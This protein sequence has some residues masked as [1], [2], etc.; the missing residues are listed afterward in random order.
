MQSIP[1]SPKISVIVPIY[2]VERY[3]RLCLDSI[4]T[5]TFTDFELLLINDGS[6]DGCPVICNEYAEK[7][8]RIRVFHKSNGGVASARNEGL[9]YAK[10]DW[11]MYIDGDDWI[12][13]TYIEDLYKAAIKNNADIAICGFRFAFEN[14]RYVTEHPALWDNNRQTSL[15]RYISSIWTTVWGSIHKSSL[16][17][18]NG[19]RSPKDI[20]YCED[21]HLMVRL[22]YFADK[23]ISIDRPLYN[24]RQR[25]ASIMHTLNKKAWRDELSAYKEIIDFFRTQGEMETYITPMSWRTLKASQDMT[26]DSSRFEEF[27]SYNPDKKKHIWDC[28]F[29][30]F[31]IK[32]L[33]FLITHGCEPIAKIITHLRKLLRR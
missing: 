19:I 5:Q 29:I 28:P 26:L 15:H 4:L 10:G 17:S 1:E 11:I 24:Y 8:A 33:A 13:P 20:T 18:T 25:S 14:G 2:N 12:E 7:D 16:Y 6:S 27:K 31:K 30:G 9:D 22:C 23:V 21:F 32:V 3:L